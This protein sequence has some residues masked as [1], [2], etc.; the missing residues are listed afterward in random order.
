MIRLLIDQKVSTCLLKGN[1]Y[2]NFTS[3]DIIGKKY[4]KYKTNFKLTT[5]EIT[6]Y[7]N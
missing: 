6:I 7:K 5:D 1:K 3:F 4:K 2:V